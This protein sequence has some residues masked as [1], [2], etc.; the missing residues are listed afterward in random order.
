MV[1]IGGFSSGMNMGFMTLDLINLK[2]LKK[3]TLNE[4]R[5]SEKL[6]T[7]MKRHT[8]L[9]VTLSLMLVAALEALP[10]FLQRLVGDPYISLAIS[11]PTT[12]FFVQVI[13]TLICTRKILPLGY[14]L[15]WVICA[16]IGIF[17]LV[18]FPI[19][20]LF[21]LIFGE[22]KPFKPEN[23]KDL[24]ETYVTDGPEG[25]EESDHLLPSGSREIPEEVSVMVAA[26]AMKE[27]TCKSAMVQINDVYM[28]SDKTVFDY[29]LM[30]EISECGHS[31]IPVY[32]NERNLI[33]GMLLTSIL[34][35]M[36]PNDSVPM[37]ALELVELPHV[38]SDMPLYKILNQFKTGKSQMAIV[39]DSN[40]NLTPIGIITLEDVI[41]T[42]IG[43]EIYD[44]VDFIKAEKKKKLL[45]QQLTKPK[46]Q[47]KTPKEQE[48]N[49][50]KAILIKKPSQK[51]EVNIVNTP[52]F[53]K[54]LI[55]N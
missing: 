49:E 1:L 23:F 50:A 34:I 51:R 39:L 5:Y 55:I 4:A 8:L 29:K 7:L 20:A 45:Q 25:Q 48:G 31:R 44:E 32:H 42:L 28:L 38:S 24:V 46:V 12:L 30:E 9:M 21:D 13:P 3:S 6:I 10:I 11:V 52:T 36:N 53:S 35:K 22:R 2:T 18:L 41:E 15:F 19:A 33:I 27:K 54:S 17:L 40:D 37:E 14:Y 16:F 43:D 26:L 47:L